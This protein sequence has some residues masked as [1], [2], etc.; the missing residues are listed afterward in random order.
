MNGEGKYKMKSPQQEA[1]E[2]TLKVLDD[3]YIERTA[4]ISKIKALKT[5]GVRTEDVIKH[6][7]EVLGVIDKNIKSLEVKLKVLVYENYR[8]EYELLRSIPGLGI[9]GIGII[10]SMLDCFRGFDNV[11]KVISYI[12]TCPKIHISGRS[13]K[14]ESRISKQ[15]SPYIRKIFFMCSLSAS[16]SNKP[17][18]DLKERLKS[19][20]K[21]WRTISIAITNKLIRQAY[22]ILK[23]NIPFDENYKHSF[24]TVS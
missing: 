22:G 23:N 20:G 12:G 9:K 13:V 17:C 15:G 19:R 7:E 4:L 5:R 1:I 16:M 10:V 6:Y 8:K 2:I 3:L 21:R 14:K 18:K 11:K 24:N